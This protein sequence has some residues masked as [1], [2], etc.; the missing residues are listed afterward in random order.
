MGT[1]VKANDIAKPK[2]KRA[3]YN[4]ATTCAEATRAQPIVN[5]TTEDSSV[6]FLPHLRLIVN[7]RCG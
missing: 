4:W 7:N 3:A 6:F 1:T 2:I 5:G